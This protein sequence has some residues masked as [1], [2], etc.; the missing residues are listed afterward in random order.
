[1]EFRFVIL[2]DCVTDINRDI[3][4]ASTWSYNFFPVKKTCM[5]LVL[6]RIN[7]DP[8]YVTQKLIKWIILKTLKLVF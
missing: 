5:W 3:S 2:F 1:M 4:Q 6:K 8:L 7:I